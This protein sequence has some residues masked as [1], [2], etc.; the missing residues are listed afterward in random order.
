MRKMKNKNSTGKVTTTTIEKRAERLRGKLQT[1]VGKP[2]PLKK[3]TKP[4]VKIQ[5]DDIENV[6]DQGW[7]VSHECPWLYL[8]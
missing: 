4:E 6:E 3:Q 1:N 2:K 7:G 5:L 8:D